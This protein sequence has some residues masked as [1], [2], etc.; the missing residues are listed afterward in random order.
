MIDTNSFRTI[1]VR[2]LESF[3]ESRVYARVTRGI[4][5]LSANLLTAI[6]IYLPHL[7]R[8][9]FPK[10]L[11]LLRNCDAISRLFTR[12][13][14]SLSLS[15]YP[16][17]HHVTRKTYSRSLRGKTSPST[18]LGFFPSRNGNGRSSLPRHAIATWEREASFQL[19]NRRRFARSADEMLLGARARRARTMRT[20]PV[21]CAVRARD[22]I[23][24][25][26]R[27]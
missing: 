23:E 25:S 2:F 4:A 24:N 26:G 3:E 12:L 27:A 18:G 20:T 22:R 11:I 8:Q 5:F 7:A 1:R 21:Y 6:I 19:Q 13:S 16:P 9:A 14:L 17:R 10:N 15:V